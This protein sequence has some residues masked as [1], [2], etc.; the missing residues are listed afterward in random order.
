MRWLRAN[1][2]SGWASSL[3][4]LGALYLV[5]RALWALVEWGLVDAVWHAP[6][7]RACIAASDGKGACWA[8]IGQWARFILFGR[9]PYAEQWR[10]LLVVLI[11]GALLAASCVRRLDGRPIMLLWAGG[12]VVDFVLMLGGAFGLPVVSTDLWSGLPLTLILA[13]VGLAAAF[14]LALLLALGRRSALPAVRA[15]SVAYIELVRGVPLITVLFMAS[16][17]VPLFL[18]DDVTIN[19]L[20]RAQAGFVLFYAAYLAEVV[21]GGL[22][23]IPL[24]QY[25]AADAL[26]LGYWRKMRL[27]ILPQAL[28]IAIPALVN[29][30]IAGFKDTTLV[31]IIG[32]FDLISTASN[33]ITD[34]EWRGFYVE[35]YGFIA[36]IYFGFCFFMSRYGRMLEKSLAR[37]RR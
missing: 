30:F 17:M 16:V 14:P 2:F 24:G 22:Q 26:G 5:A 31:T 6:N 3:V 33:A 4:T 29:I 12:F 10:P 15:L 25:E 35:A 7:G 11:F 34:P 20:L 9:Y 19:K 23:A 32:L 18:P 28:V 36:V 21:R 27:V 8:F 37:S 13:V 1:L